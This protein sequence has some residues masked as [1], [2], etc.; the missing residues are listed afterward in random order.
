LVPYYQNDEF[1]YSTAV[2]PLYPLG[3]AT[4]PM[5]PGTLLASARMGDIQYTAAEMDD[6]PLLP[7]DEAREKMLRRTGL[8]SCGRNDANIYAP[9]D[10]EDFLPP[11]PGSSYLDPSFGC[12]IT[13]LSD[14]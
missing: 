3:L 4:I 2:A 1:F 8:V 10:Y 11:A 14:G 7:D 6:G 9:L 12:I 5:E 13:S